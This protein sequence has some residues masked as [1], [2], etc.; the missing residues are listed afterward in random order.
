MYNKIIL[1][2]NLGKDPETKTFDS[3]NKVCQFTMATSETYKDKQ[4]GERKTNT[5][6][7]NIVIWGPIA[8]VAQ[9][10]LK[11]GSQCMV[12]GKMTNRSY[13]TPEGE[14]KYISE[15]VV[16]ELKLLGSRPDSDGS[17]N[18]SYAPPAQAQSETKKEESQLSG[19]A[20]EPIDDLP[21]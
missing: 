10:Y 1:I 7:H 4:T 20:A 5:E 8:D 14:K 19:A 2:G 18:Q 3:G 13:D 9:N 15:V 12:E 6:W 11:K 16:R 17:N 21:F